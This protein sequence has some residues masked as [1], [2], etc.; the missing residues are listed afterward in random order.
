MLGVNYVYVIPY[1]VMYILISCLSLFGYVYLSECLFLFLSVL[2]CSV[3]LCIYIMRVF[4]YSQSVGSL[5]IFSVHPMVTLDNIR[6]IPQKCAQQQ[7]QLSIIISSN[8]RT[9]HIK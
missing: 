9:L 8:T 6:Y 2:E 7:Q 1:L 5:I 3:F 4:C